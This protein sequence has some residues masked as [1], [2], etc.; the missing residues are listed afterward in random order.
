MGTDFP[1]TATSL[2]PVSF[3]MYWL[4]KEVPGEENIAQKRPSM[5]SIS[6]CLKIDTP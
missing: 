4:A 1:T 3:V 2:A 5:L 6:L